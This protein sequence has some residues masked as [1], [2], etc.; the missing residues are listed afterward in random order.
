MSYVTK[1]IALNGEYWY[2]A[3][4]EGDHH[5]SNKLSKIYSCTL[6]EILKILIEDYKDNYRIQI[7]L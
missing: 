1:K 6:V 2:Q 5:S 7:Y 3:H 4:D